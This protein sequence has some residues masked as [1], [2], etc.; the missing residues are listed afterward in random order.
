[1]DD[2]ALEYDDQGKIPRDEVVDTRRV[3]GGIS[4]GMEHKGLKV[5][6]GGM[7]VPFTSEVAKV[8]S[9]QAREIALE[10][11]R[12]AT[13]AYDEKVVSTL[14]AVASLQASVIALA[15]DP[16]SQPDKQEMEKL[17]LGLSAAEQILNRVMGKP[18]TRI[19]GEVQHS[20]IGDMA[21][22]DAEWIIDE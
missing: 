10:R 21:S 19:E 15:N 4:V 7:R 20:V 1:M 2:S 14:E 17:R 9:A 11:K 12:K 3:V 16:R 13:E 8:R 22:V 5:G 18:T 6:N